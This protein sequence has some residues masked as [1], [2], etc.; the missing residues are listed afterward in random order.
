MI[1][2][3]MLK[4]LINLITTGFSQD[5]K[6][7]LRVTTLDITRYFYFQFFVEENVKFKWIITFFLGITKPQNCNYYLKLIEAM[8]EKFIS[9]ERT[10]WF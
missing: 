1:V 3:V 2:P 9:Q 10:M 4:P 8:L 6:D 7:F 5:Y